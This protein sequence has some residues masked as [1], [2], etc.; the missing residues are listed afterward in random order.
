MAGS[1]QVRSARL[2][3]QIAPRGQKVAR[4]DASGKRHSVWTA[5][6]RWRGGPAHGLVDGSV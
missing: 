5:G 4:G 6:P 2:R 3:A 1:T